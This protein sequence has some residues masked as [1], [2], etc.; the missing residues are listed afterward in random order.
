MTSRLM[1]KWVA[2]AAQYRCVGLRGSAA[3]ATGKPPRLGPASLLASHAR[4][5]VTRTL[6][7]NVRPSLEVSI[8]RTPSCLARGL[9]GSGGELLRGEAGAFSPG[10][11]T[12]VCTVSSNR[13]RRGAAVEET[14]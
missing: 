8:D 2:L 4:K 9:R 14:G 13:A 1:P 3:M 7:I 6:G 10:L 5:A 11:P 12:G